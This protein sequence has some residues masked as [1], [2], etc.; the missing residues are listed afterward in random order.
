MPK[1]IASQLIAAKSQ[2]VALTSRLLRI[3]PLVDGSY[4]RLTNIDKDELYDFGGSICADGLGVQRYYAA[5]GFEM[6]TIEATNDLAVDNADAQSLVPVYPMPGITPDLVQAGKLDTIPYVVIEHDCINGAA[7][8]HEIMASGVLGKCRME[9]GLVA[10]PALRSWSELLNQTGIISETSI[11]CRAKHFGSQPGDEREFC[12]FDLTGEWIPFT[13]SAI[14]TEVVREFYVD[15]LTQVDDWFAPGLVH[16]TAGDNIDTS[17]EVESF[18]G[19]VDSPSGTNAYVSLRF[20]TRKP[21]QVGD[22]GEIR[23][24]CTRKYTGHN[25][26]QTYFGDD[27]GLHF[28]GE[29][30]INIGDTTAN[31]IPGVNMTTSTGGTGEAF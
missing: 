1:T 15:G 10:I 6:T 5:T 3:G 28:R 19:S 11:D 29:P 16:W 13:V 4:I 8:E 12:G 7:G 2:G 18:T 25:S 26:C 17:Q 22:V 30:F 24:E 23:R 20:T 9:N 14:G 21:V 27:R 31:T